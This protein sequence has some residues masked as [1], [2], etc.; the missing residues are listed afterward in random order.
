MVLKAA[1]RN[2]HCPEYGV[3][4]I[5]FP[6]PRE[7]YDSTIQMLK[8]LDIGDVIRQDCTVEEIQ[9]GWPVLQ[10]LEGTQVNLDELDYLAKRLDSFDTGEAAQ[11]QGMACKLNLTD[12][13]DLINLTFSC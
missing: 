8:G 11:F 9:G 7:G 4:T 5:P 3:V 1:L 6:I 2:E 10:R 13:K 12:M